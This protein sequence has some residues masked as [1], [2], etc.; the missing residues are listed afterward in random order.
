MPRPGR[1]TAG[2]ESRQPFY[3]RLGGPQRQFVRVRKISPPSVLGPRT[4]QLAATTLSQ[5]TFTSTLCPICLHGV[6]EDRSTFTF[7]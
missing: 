7:P 4:V 1:F 6:Q 5:P 3:K 2:N